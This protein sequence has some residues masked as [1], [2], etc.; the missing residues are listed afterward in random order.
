LEMTD[1]TPAQ[2]AAQIVAGRTCGACMMCCKV[3]HI[4]EFNKPAGVWCQHAIP[5][6]GCGIYA[7]RPGA[8]RAFYCSWMQDASLGPEWKPDRAKFVVYLQRNGVNLQ[9]A[10][11]PGFPNAWMKPPYYARI[12]KW[13]RD[14]AE[15]GAFVFV[16]IGPRMIVALP[17]RDQDIGRVDPE[18]EIVVSRKPG[19]AGFVYDIEVKRA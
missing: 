6:K 17:D 8:C 16:R 19:V 2:D 18:D 13:A 11:D 1:P 3:P 14:G 5:G 10:V 9:V 4:E 15:T 7:E 12:K